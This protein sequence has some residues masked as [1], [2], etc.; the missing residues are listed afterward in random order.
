MDIIQILEKNRT[1]EEYHTHVSMDQPKGK[2]LIDRN[3]SES[4]WKEYLDDIYSGKSYSIAEKPQ[5]IMPVLVDVDIKKETEEKD[6]LYS[7]EQLE[8]MVHNY[9]NA[10]K[11]ILDD[12]KSENLY[13]FVLE[14]PSYQIEKDGKIFT[15]QGF[16]LHFPYTFLTK[17]DQINHLLPRVKKCKDGELIDDCHTR[18]PWLLYGSVKKEG[19]NPYLLTKIYDENG[20]IIT[21]E[22]ALKNYKI[23]DVNENPIQ[24]NN[25]SLYLPRILSII[26]WHRPISE[27]QKNL[28][29]VIKNEKKIELEDEDCT[30][31]RSELIN[32]YLEVIKKSRFKN[33]S[34][35]FSLCKIMRKNNLSRD[36]FI[37]Y[38]EESG[39]TGFNPEECNKL[40]FTIECKKTPGFPTLQKWCEEDGIDW[41]SM[42]C[43]KKN[44]MIQSLIN[45]IKDFGK[46]TEFS[47]AEAFFD[48]YKDDFYHTPIGWLKYTDKWEVGDDESIIFPFMKKI[49]QCFNSYAHTLKDDLMV[50]MLKQSIVLVSYSFVSKVIKTARSLFKND[51]ILNKFDRKDTWFCFSDGKAID[52]LTKN[53]IIIKKEDFIITTCGYPMPERNHIYMDEVKKI[54]NGI[55]SNYDN[56]MMMDAYDFQNGNPDQIMKIEQG[57][58]GN[59]KSLKNLLKIKS[60]GNYAGTLPIDQLTQFSSGR[61]STNSGIASMRG[62]RYCQ[63]NEP[64]DDKQITL[65][66]GCIKEL[67]GEAEITVR[68]LY[69]KSA[70]MRIQFKP[71]IVCN[72]PP[73]LSKSDEAIERRIR[74]HDYP[75]Q[76]V[77]EPTLPHHRKK[78]TSLINR[79][80]TNENLQHA[81]LFLIIDK[82]TE[83]KGRFIITEEVKQASN[84]YMKENNP[85]AIF[86]E[87]YTHSI[88]FIRQP[89]LY[90]KYQNWCQDKF[91]EVVSSRNFASYIYQLKFK[92]IPDLKHGN[93]IYCQ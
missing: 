62:K 33:Y 61:D 76:F 27:L 42:F 18:N 86:M 71:T 81:Y 31:E 74:V 7:I 60:L 10:L 65:K 13:C 79:C 28:Q 93:K 53:I 59:G 34:D 48:N 87:D 21:L 46:L 91:Q 66:V 5:N 16:H 45:G 32:K 90:K 23:Y 43:Q 84:D 36:K 58:G 8:N 39:Y 29:N 78:D 52:M 70:T 85:I 9:Q 68:N 6:N 75:Y 2:F 77:D 73:K 44:K 37:K 83:T 82:F 17:N 51:M 24:I 22:K 15:K 57:S 49:G 63:F 89:I 54:I 41:K 3:A 80:E 56:F 19:M 35:W 25:H 92:V 12:C 64:E 1:F 40:W 38:S 11:D 67:T 4:F 50:S 47:V 26:P 30:S 72:N 88:N 69:E 55:T 20:N 14:K